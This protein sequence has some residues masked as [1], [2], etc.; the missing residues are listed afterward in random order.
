MWVN[1]EI[2]ERIKEILVG[3]T[4]S[5]LEVLIEELMEKAHQKGYEEG[6]LQGER[7]RENDIAEMLS[8]R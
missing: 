7:D 4:Y 5:E 6:H 1:D 8:D 2:A 3:A